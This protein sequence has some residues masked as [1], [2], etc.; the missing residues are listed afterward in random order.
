MTEIKTKK[1]K[2]KKIKIKGVLFLLIVLVFV[3]FLISSFLNMPIKN[4][5]ISGTN[6]INDNEIIEKAD[7][8]DYPPIFRLNF[9]KVENKL[10]EIP[11]IKSV[12]IKRNIFG[13]LTIEVIED[14]VLFLNKNTNQI[15]LSDAKEI[16]NSNN[17]YRI[18]T[19]IN[20][21]PD[22]IYQDLISG[23]NKVD[24]DI[25]SSISEIEYSPSLNDKQ[26]IIDDTRFYLRMND[27]NAIY[28][29]IVNIKRLN[30]YNTIYASIYASVN[31]EKGTF[32]LD[33]IAEDN[34]YFKSFASE[35]KEKEEDFA[36]QEG[37]DDNEKPGEN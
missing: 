32:H 20:Y 33:S 34:I 26:E 10:L 29:N 1:V 8:K 28:M 16:D 31:G 36:K 21:V 37:N 3:I 9:K 35:K 4:I 12:N 7:I 24:Y 25:V 13:R 19:L 15:V 18:P 14:K 22:T 17:Y 5:Y 2:K 6:I 23:L 30:S 27:G 11:L